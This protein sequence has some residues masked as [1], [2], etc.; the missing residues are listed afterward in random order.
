MKE[1]NKIVAICCIAILATIGSILLYLKLR[2]FRHDI[3]ETIEQ[4]APTTPLTQ[5]DVVQPDHSYDTSSRGYRNNNP[6][7]LR[8]SSA[9]NWKGEIKPSADGSFCQFVSMAYGFRAAM[10]CIR[11]YIRKYNLQ[12]IEQIIGRWA[13]W[14]DGNNPTRYTNFVVSQWPDD[15][16][17][18]TIIDYTS[19]DQMT[20]LVFAMAIMENGSEPLM[21][22]CHKGFELM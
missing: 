13:P 15:F 12:T 1:T 20:K 11:T 19:K 8:I 7:N 18:D 2:R 21:A 5:E 9:N 10:I 3:E 14:A 4:E 6:L 22:D 16:T 17:K